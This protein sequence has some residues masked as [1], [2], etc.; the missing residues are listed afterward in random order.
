M[1]NNGNIYKKLTV[2]DDDNNTFSENGII[3]FIVMNR[4]YNYSC[5]QYYQFSLE[6]TLAPPPPPIVQYLVGEGPS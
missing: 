2:I 1:E 3:R 5:A 6:C 4:L